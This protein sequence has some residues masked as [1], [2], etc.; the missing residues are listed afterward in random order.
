MLNFIVIFNC[1]GAQYIKQ[2][3]Q[4]TQF[5]AIYNCVYIPIYNYLPGGISSNSLNFIQEDIDKLASADA[6]LIQHIKTDRGFLNH[7]NIIK[8][9][10]SS[11][12]IIKIPH[13]TFSGYHMD[14]NFEPDSAILYDTYDKIKNIIFNSDIVH[15]HLTNE[16]ENIRNL[17]ELSDISMYDIVKDNYANYK[18]FY[19]RQYPTYNF[20]F[21]AAKQILKLLQIDDELDNPVFTGYAAHLDIPIFPNVTDI[22][23]L[24]FDNSKNIVP[25]I[26]TCIELNKKQLILQNRKTGRIDLQRY[27]EIRNHIANSQNK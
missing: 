13:Y 17:D 18:L 1:H 12:I 21:F 6:L 11:C 25:Y 5:N 20:F 22:L 14:Y 26:L 7:S 24:K 15:E 19:C 4:S 8:M 9:V 2:L 10:K 23:K 16:L 3:E 27:N